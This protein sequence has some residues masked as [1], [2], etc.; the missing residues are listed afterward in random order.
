MERNSQGTVDLLNFDEVFTQQETSG[1]KLTFIIPTDVTGQMES[2]SVG[3]LKN[4]LR[5]AADELASA[6]LREREVQEFLAPVRE[7]LE[8]S[9]YWRL[10]SRSLI[11]FLSEGFHQAIRLPIELPASLTVGENFNLLPLAP[12]LASD[13]KLY[14]LALAQNSVRLFETTRNVIEEL[15]LDGIPASFDEVIEILPERTVDVRVGSAGTSGTPSFHGPDGDADR[16]LLETFIGEVGQAVEKR[17]G[18]ARSQLLVLAAVAEYHPIFTSACDYPA[19]FDG[20]IAGNPERSLPD[21]LRSQAWRL[22]NEHELERENQEEDDAISQAHAGR[23]SFDPAEIRRAAEM[24]RVDTLYLARDSSSMS[25]ATQELANLA[26]IDTLKN[27]GVLRTL[28][29]ARN[30]VLATFRY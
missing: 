16:M 10:Q 22:V 19:I 23:G 18:T 3:T 8:D 9:T 13:R 21:E 11:V 20:V 24:G 14:I 6:G 27:S 30:E 12:V 7:L 4:Q 25:S 5:E 1:R 26:L 17:L 29:P 28:E 15:P 2:I